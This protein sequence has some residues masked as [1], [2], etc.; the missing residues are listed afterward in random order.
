L[1]GGIV[2]S[3]LAARGCPVTLV[4][5][6]DAPAPL[7]PTDE[8]WEPADARTFFTRGSGIGGTSNFWHGGLTVLDRSD[9]E[10]VPGHDG[11]AR[12][13]ITYERLRGY[14]A[15]AVDLLRGESPYSLGDIE[16][17]PGMPAGGFENT[18]D[19]FRLKALLY[20]DRPFSSR[21]LIPRAQE[22]HGLRVVSNT[23]IRRLVS[24]V[25]RRITR[26]EGVDLRSGAPLKFLADIFVVSAG[27]LGSPK[28]L[29]PSASDFPP[30]AQLPIGRFIIDHPSGFLF[31]AKLRRRMDLTPLFGVTRKGHKLRY[32][33]ALAPDRLGDAEFR[34]HILYLRPA[35]TMKDPGAYDFLKR[36]LVAYRGKFLSPLDLAYLVR[37]ADLLFDAVNFRYG[38]SY[39]TRYVSGLVFAEQFPDENRRIRRLEDGKFG[40]KWAVSPE[41]C[42]SLEGFLAAFFERYAEQFESFRVFPDTSTRLDS[43]GH[44]SGACRMALNA[45]VGVVDA[46][47]QV[48]GTD[49]L[50]VADGSTLPYSGHANTGLTIAALALKCCDSIAPRNS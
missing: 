33:F 27:G 9:V 25:P 8:V 3:T 18:G 13:P 30:L 17:P 15:Q 49:N 37:H 39:S 32:G 12:A 19:R 23:E 16:D 44:H 5:L 48:F 45:S 35:L 36:K 50:F 40:I 42:R 11:R 10:G 24:A 38:L 2:A 22:L 14:Y 41:D 34:N 20:P 7:R 46:D 4:E 28:I 31:K 47:L 1:A 43:A 26:A 29:L 6:G 21:T